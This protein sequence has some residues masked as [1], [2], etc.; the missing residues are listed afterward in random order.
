[1]KVYACTLC[2]YEYVEEDG[3][4]EN[5]VEEGTEFED[6]P[7]DWVCPVCG[8]TKEEFELVNSDDE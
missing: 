2:G 7:A 3:D 6:I 8:A 5:G 1:M 4:V